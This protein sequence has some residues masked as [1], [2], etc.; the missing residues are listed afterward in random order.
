MKA[1]RASL[2]V[3][4]ALIAMLSLVMVFGL[5]TT[6]AYFKAKGLIQENSEVL[7]SRANNSALRS[8]SETLDT[9]DDDVAFLNHSENIHA[10][11]K[12]FNWEFR[13]YGFSAREQLHSD[14]ITNS[15]HGDGEKHLLD[16]AEGLQG[17]HNV[18]AKHH[19]TIREFLEINGFTDIFLINNDGNVVYS[20]FKG[21]DFATN[22]NDAEYA[23][24]DLGAVF[25]EA[26]ASLDPEFVAFRDLSPYA[27]ANNA[28]SG[29]MAR[30]IWEEGKKIGVLAVRMPISRINGIFDV[31]TDEHSRSYFVGSDGLSRIDLNETAEN[32]Q[33]SLALPFLP[34][35]MDSNVILER[36]AGILGQ[37]VSIEM[38]PLSFH[39]VDWYVF[40]ERDTAIVQAGVADLT[41]GI[42]LQGLPV[43]TILSL[44]AWI[45][46]SRGV[47]PVTQLSAAITDAAEGKVTSVPLLDR[48]DELGNLAR[49]FEQVHGQMLRSQQVEFAIASSA[50]PALIVD[51]NDIIVFTNPSMNAMLS[52][53]AT[54][55][56]AVMGAAFDEDIQGKRLS[57]YQ[58]YVDTTTAKTAVEFDGR[59]F[60]VAVA[61]IK[62]QEGDE[63]GFSLEWEEI[64]ERLAVEAQVATVIEE[65]ATGNF[66]TQ[67][68]I[69]TEDAFIA[70]LANGMN[71]ISEIVSN[72][73]GE[74][75]N[76]FDAVAEGDLSKRLSSNYEGALATA[77]N[78]MNTSISDLAEQH[79]R[80][81]RRTVALENIQV[82]T[83]ICDPS[84][85]VVFANK[86]CQE[87][88]NG[89][90][91]ITSKLPSADLQ[92]NSL[93][94]ICNVLGVDFN[95]YHGAQG[96]QEI[97]FRFEGSYLKLNITPAF[98]G[99][100]ELIG[101]CSQW[102]DETSIKSIEA[103]ISDV[104]H[105]ATDGNFSKRI[106]VVTDDPFRKSMMSGINQISNVVS[107]FLAEISQATSALAKGN[108]SYNVTKEF[109]GDFGSAVANINEATTNLRTLIATVKHSAVELDKTAETTTNDSNE[110]SDRAVNQAASIEQTSA[111]LEE[112]RI[113]TNNTNEYVTTATDKVQSV[114]TLAESGLTI[115]EKAVAAIHEI[116]ANATKISE[117]T[118]VVN[119]IA[120]QTN[121]LALNASVE[122]ARAGDAGKG[123]AVVANEVRTLASRSHSA[124]EDIGKLISDSSQS[125]GNGVDLVTK[126]G[127]V[128]HDIEGSINEMSEML[129]SIS[130]AS[131]E[132][133]GG[134]SEISEAISQIDG[135]TQNN[136]V[137]ASKTATNATTVRDRA[138]ELT[139]RMN[140]FDIGNETYIATPAA[141]SATSPASA[142]SQPS[143]DE[144]EKE[145]SADDTQAL[146]AKALQDQGDDGG[147][148]FDLSA[149]TGTDDEWTDF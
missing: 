22:L 34:T 68:D 94:N 72:F 147:A 88:F 29:F 108:L 75:I 113:T 111:A 130:T 100:N 74:T 3:K 128:L 7:V 110:L 90:L 124:S 81:N 99:E 71:R 129:E 80:S 125:V 6:S 43:L 79:N 8:L 9:I 121:L 1:V 19:Q 92:A 58:L 83:M 40:T 18:H 16:R 49:S 67:L 26:A 11:M 17:Y 48:S 119:Q 95:D 103:Q 55:F 14:Y 54:H 4:I 59:T 56:R 38:Q 70:S 96:H 27:P 145:F 140:T 37:P 105:A 15:P 76:L 136:S 142:P 32:D 123:F 39:G 36:S 57:E 120:F 117:F 118:E 62:N 131:T 13:S 115:A 47:K 52:V 104:I 82:S 87:L 144:W 149:L 114:T 133:S 46:V 143:K 12:E 93:Q 69:K 91:A 126:T 86:A 31:L 41:Y 45:A 35:E 139:T 141:S 134:I 109:K 23:S 42:I 44:V 65:A 61:R 146:I 66:D 20:V 10:A 24:S 135:I 112:I 50:T 33:L 138:V 127:K 102:S 73:L 85:N 30:A 77:A 64:T 98:D 101:F 122:A 106:Q 25:R 84:G 60:N 28:L 51:E 107:E 63:R 132:Q 21:L 53:S 5:A 78:G 116:E 89:K 137:L 148:G 97:E 2:S